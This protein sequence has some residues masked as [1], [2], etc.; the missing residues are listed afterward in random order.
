MS[1]N[2]PIRWADNTKD[3]ARN[4]A[5]GVNQIE[6]TTAA[7][8]KMTRAL[9][10]ERLMQSANNY[11]AAL[12]KIGAAGGA[13]AGVESLTNKEREKGLALLDKAITKYEAMGK[14]APTAIY[15][16][17]DAMKSAADATKGWGDVL[18]S[19]GGG[20]VARIASGVL[21]RDAVHEIIDVTKEAIVYLP[22]LAL[23]GA[24]IA[25]V[26]DSFKHLTAQ[27]GLLAGSLM[28]ELQSG[29]HNTVTNFEL[30]KR[31][32]EDLSAG[33]NLTTTQFGTL[34]K[35]AFALA[36][37]TGGDVKT[38]LDT[39]NDA[40]VT[41]RTRALAMLVGKISQTQAEKD[42]AASLLSSADHLTDEGKLEASRA[43]MLEV[44]G[45]VIERL[46]VQTDGLDENV[47]QAQTAWKNFEEELGKTIA[48]SAAVQTA[49]AGLTTAIVSALGDNSQAV[50]DTI[51][52]KVDEFAVAIVSASVVAV[53]AGG[54]IAKEWYAL[55]KVFMFVAQ[56]LDEITF[57]GAKASG[58]E[59]ALLDAATK[60]GDPVAKRQS[61]EGYAE[62]A[63]INQA[64]A[65]RLK[66]FNEL[67]EAQ[68]GQDASTAALVKTLE[69][70]R[71]KVQGVAAAEA[72]RHASLMV[73]NEQ[74]QEWQPSGK[75]DIPAPSPSG[76]PAGGKKLLGPSNEEL[77]EAKRAAKDYAE[78]WYDLSTLGQT[79]LDTLGE[80]NPKIREEAQYWAN[81]GASVKDLK[82][83]F[84]GMT[85]A[86]AGALVENAKHIK[87]YTEAWANAN[88][89]SE[90]YQATV[91]ALSGE[92]VE[93]VR[94][95]KAA[96]LA[97][98]D[99]AKMFE[100]DL[101]TAQINA[102][103][104]LDK[105]AAEHLKILDKMR[106]VESVDMNANVK[107]WEHLGVVVKGQQEGFEG[108]AKDYARNQDYIAKSTMTAADYR[109]HKIEEIRDAELR[110]LNRS[111]EGWKERE[112]QIKA[113]AD[114][115]I[116]DVRFAQ[117]SIETMLGR[118]SADADRS[119]AP[120]KDLGRV[121][122]GLGG[123][124]SNMA[125]LA[126]D[127]FGSMGRSAAAGLS[128]VMSSVGKYQDALQKY[129]PTDQRTKDAKANAAWA[130]VGSGA[131]LIAQ[132]I[133]TGAGAPTKNLIAAGALQGAAAG[134]P[135]AVATGG[136]SVGV[137][138]GVGALIGW[139]Q[140]GVEWRKVYS[141][142]SRDF[143]NIKVS[144]D[145]A[146]LIDTLESQTGL[147]RAQAITTQLDKLIEQ[148]GGLTT[149]NLDL[150]VSKLHDAFSYLQQGGL[151]TAQTTQVIDKNFENMAKVGTDSLGRI[152]DKL[153]EIIDLDQHFATH[154]SAITAW[155]SGQAETIATGLADLLDQP[156]IHAADEVG[157][158]VKAAQDA[159]DKQT[160]AVAKAADKT[161]DYVAATSNLKKAQDDLTAAHDKGAKAVANAQANVDKYQA[162]VDR[163]AGKSAS[164]KTAT[165]DLS[166][167]QDELTDALS[168]QS[169]E[170]DRNKQAI[171]DLGSA[172]I[173]AFGAAVAGGASFVDA[174]TLIAGPLST[175]NKAVKDLGLSLDD[176]NDGGFKG[177][178]L[179][180]TI[181]NGEDGK[182][183][184]GKSIGGLQSLV[185]ASM[186]IPGL[187]KPADF[188][189]QQRILDNLYIQTQAA[190]HAAGGDTINALLPFQQV[191][192]LMDDWATKNH[193]V[194]DDATQEK[195]RQSKELGLWTADFRT[196]AEKQQQ[197]ILDL[198]ASNTTLVAALGG[199]PSAL[200][201]VMR[202][203]VAP[204]PPPLD[205]NDNPSTGG[206]PTAPGPARPPANGR[207]VDAPPN[208]E[209][210]SGGYGYAPGP[211]T[212]STQGREFYAFSGE[213][214]SF[215]DTQAG[216]SLGGIAGGGYTG[217][218]NAG[219][220][221]ALVQRLASPSVPPPAVGWPGIGDVVTALKD[222][223]STLADTATPGFWDSSRAGG[224]GLATGGPTTGIAGGGYTGLGNTTALEMLLQRLEVSSPL[225]SP[226]PTGEFSA[227]PPTSRG[228][229]IGVGG[230]A[231]GITTTDTS[232]AVVLK[233]E[234]T[235]HVTLPQ[236]GGMQNG[237][238]VEKELMPQIISQIE[239][240]R[241]GY[242][243]RLRR[244]LGVEVTG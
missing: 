9:S 131:D 144:E 192:H 171:E 37:A 42:Y 69:E 182:G 159:V 119:V 55:E 174:L 202:T 153:K 166:K 34:A 152:S 242:T 175:I 222:V 91:D 239:D 25:D 86:Q 54:A 30:M 22:K 80:L 184:V 106:G 129:G 89:V 141:D 71:Q 72:A 41:G 112:D 83:A 196:D 226:P 19:L 156:M 151:S 99:L 87:T 110:A 33:L 147:Q 214:Q 218:G 13:L 188:A 178:L 102:I 90:N 230:P 191:L 111:V 177:L 170:A 70:L 216:G 47:A 225:V 10:G 164:F 121:A 27:S 127:A 209:M 168:Q 35:G 15:E 243:S 92:L 39:M 172:A 235:F 154:S 136:I 137:G 238:Y 48:T 11:A 124:F 82:N 130:A 149:D 32:N 65:D 237:E 183:G 105:T 204:T 26:E 208:V 66:A 74:E 43:K 138:A 233:E 224:F 157:Q 28:T 97:V 53:K 201:E 117:E 1:I 227:V 98:G 200:A 223:T 61:Q 68:H 104:Q 163:A 120:L 176:I 219:A 56:A 6:V 180:N 18:E 179:M 100:G 79:Y 241:R 101:T 57:L 73:W 215:Q 103:I 51:V 114:K 167:A 143:G 96:G 146:K 240:G 45:L 5:E 63:R 24:R 199:L 46:G 3:L 187:E 140:S 113:L 232:K 23:E 189:S 59:N 220:L 81:A 194:L 181:L 7:A 212:F 198:I 38:A 185:T 67:T 186:N 108:Y 236:G 84:T 75:M 158:R 132:N 76:P 244:A 31:V 133:N 221:D 126:G 195:I 205:T 85:D 160:D 58:Y 77:A 211:M 134:A 64:M 161:Q 21:L 231:T 20:M 36:Q 135:F 8:E 162:A 49:M 203:G 217:L 29:T 150:F 234:F 2:I 145:F 16:V 60:G 169:Q 12:Q 193:M 88:S 173:T 95:Y 197:S 118:I 94:Y 206:V 50:I 125:S 139:Y 128:T 40:M 142:I 14:S 17:R 78:A 93:S 148:A 107:E 229:A 228:G 123:T 165:D 190:T 62:A 4:L 210:A 109:V 213:G 44:V 207:P 52:K 116:Q 115:E 155:I 122:E